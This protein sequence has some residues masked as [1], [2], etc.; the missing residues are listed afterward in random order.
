VFPGLPAVL[1]PLVQAR[2]CDV[3]NGH[4]D[5]AFPGPRRIEH[6][7]TS[8]HRAA[9]ELVLE[10]HDARDRPGRSLGR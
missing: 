3:Q 1:G 9:A 8:A 5:C 6:A 4:L 7:V 2:M 10:A